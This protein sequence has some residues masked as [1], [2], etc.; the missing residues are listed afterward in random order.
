LL[1]DHL[2]ALL[3]QGFRVS[4]RWAAVH[5]ALEVVHPGEP[6]WYL[7][8]L[9]VNPHH[10]RCGIGGALLG[11]WLDSIEADGLPSYLETDR[12]ENVH[13][14]ERMGFSVQVKLQVLEANV[15]CMR[16]PS[17]PGS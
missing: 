1:L 14:Y 6:H 9:G 17:E 5:R 12:E 7:S 4:A 10:Q 8:L 2:R 16:R 15:W 3:G 11:S 13:F